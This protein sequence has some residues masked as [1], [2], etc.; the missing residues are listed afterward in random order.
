MGYGDVARA[1]KVQRG[2]ASEVYDAARGPGGAPRGWRDTGLGAHAAAQQGRHLVRVAL[3]VVRCAAMEGCPREGMPQHA[4]QAFCG[5][6]VGEP[7]PGDKTCTGHHQAVPRRGNGLEKR[8]GGCWQMA[9]EPHVA[10]LAQ[11]TDIHAPGVE[12][13]PTVK[14]MVLGVESPEGSSSLLVAFPNA[15]RTNKD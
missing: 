7:I 12:G 2:G 6:Q 4:G 10:R 9:G 15:S 1:L 8:C 14:R 5:T 3:V 11:D 13:D